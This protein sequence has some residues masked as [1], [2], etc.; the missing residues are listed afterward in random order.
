MIERTAILEREGRAEKRGRRRGPDDVDRIL[1][2]KLAL[3]VP[4][5]TSCARC[6]ETEKR[7]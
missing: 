5:S 7:I 6:G 2:E 3:D 1:K 4:G